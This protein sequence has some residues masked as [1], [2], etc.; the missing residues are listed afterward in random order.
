MAKIRERTLQVVGYARCSTSEQA[1]EGMSIDAQTARIRAW[2]EIEGA[3]IAEVV[4]DAGV[5]GAK[6]LAD[7]EG[8]ALIAHLLDVK[9]GGIDA[10]VVVRTDRLGRNAAETLALLRRF[11]TGPVGLVS[12]AEHIDL[13][14]PHGRAMAGVAAVFA[15]LERDLIA[16][17]T[18]DSLAELRA[19]GL[20]W[21][22]PP[23]GWNVE[24]RRLVPEPS[25]LETLARA[26]ELRWGGDSYGKI[27]RTLTAEGRPTKR[28]GVWQSMSVRSVLRTAETMGWTPRDTLTARKGEV[29]RRDDS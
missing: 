18:V 28:G 19:Q 27:A 20:A 5:S 9:G 16:E 13:A 1:N 4:I 6:P 10:V 21:N 7:R 24:D 29:G 14:T 17:R 25:E 23:F 26:I 8:G 2:A 15:E 22:H 11:R 12:V 3:E